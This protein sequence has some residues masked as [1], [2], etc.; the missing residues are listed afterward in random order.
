[1]SE[2]S[3]EEQAARTWDFK[4]KETQPVAKEAKHPTFRTTIVPC[5]P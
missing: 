4:E 5:L 3:T 2:T 1:M